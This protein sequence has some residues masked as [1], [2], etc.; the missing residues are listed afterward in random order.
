MSRQG[1]VLPDRLQTTWLYTLSKQSALYF[2]GR[3]SRDWNEPSQSFHNHGEGPSIRGFSWGK[4]MIFAPESKYLVSVFNQEKALKGVFSVI[5]NFGECSFQALTGTVL[6][7]VRGQ[8][9]R[10]SCY[11]EPPFPEAKCSW[12]FAVIIMRWWAFLVTCFLAPHSVNNS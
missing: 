1:Q 7:S 10:P 8:E 11:K 5:V 2:I 6:V 4:V 3:G 9:S 12:S